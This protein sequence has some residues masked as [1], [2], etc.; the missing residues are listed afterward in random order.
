MVRFG[1]GGSMN[2]AWVLSAVLSA[3]SVGAAA[4]TQSVASPVAPA[5]S[6]TPATIAT[7]AADTPGAPTPSST[8]AGVRLAVDTPI[9][10]ELAEI[11]SSKTR[12]GGE[13]FAIRL[14]SPIVVDGR[15]LAP[16]GAVGM[17]Q[18]VYAEAGGAGGSP[19]KLVLAARYIDVGSV[20]V[21]LKAFNLS[22]GGESEFREMQVAAQLIGPAVFLFDGHDV[23]YPVGT[24]ARAK[25]AADVIL[26]AVPAGSVPSAAPATSTPAVSSIIAAKEPA[27]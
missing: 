25:V 16:A 13:T 11:V 21:R 1:G 14:A 4:Q 5:A 24:R 7:P 19:G 2:K 9:R 27:K 8:D 20:R 26:T 23:V 10:I 22:A 6:V 15:M 18:V 17:G 3:W 12:K